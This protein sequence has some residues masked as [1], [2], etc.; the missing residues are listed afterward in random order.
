MHVRP[1]LLV[2]LVFLVSRLSFGAEGIFQGTVVAPPPSESTSPGWIFVEG[3]NH[4]LRRVEVAHATIVFGPGVSPSQK[5]KCGPD[6]LS[7][8]QEVRVTAQQDA[9][10]EWRARRV[11]ILREAV[12]PLSGLAAEGGRFLLP[13]GRGPELGAYSSE[14]TSS[15][16]L[17]PSPGS[18]LTKLNS[19][20]LF[21]VA[22]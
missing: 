17:W 20:L 9:S 5:R 12:K 7:A 16:A 11:E 22:G 19:G 10:G 4:L 15:W 8:G 21:G 13:S 6:C 18:S 14:N 3:G 1:Q 2:L